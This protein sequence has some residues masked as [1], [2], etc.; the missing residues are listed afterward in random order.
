[1]Q[2]ICRMVGL[3]NKILHTVVFVAS[4]FQDVRSSSAAP[5]PITFSFYTLFFPFAFFCNIWR[6][7]IAWPCVGWTNLSKLCGNTKES[8]LIHFSFFYLFSEWNIVNVC[9]SY[10]FIAFRNKLYIL[11]PFSTR[12]RAVMYLDVWWFCTGKLPTSQLCFDVRRQ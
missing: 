10:S 9:A 3:L 8:V 5:A 4:S 2:W 7:R 1:M 12:S 11:L 6:M